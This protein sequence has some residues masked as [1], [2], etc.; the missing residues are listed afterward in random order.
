[1]SELNPPEQSEQ[2]AMAQM[3]RARKSGGGGA[4]GPNHTEKVETS[5]IRMLD[6]RGK[7]Y[8]DYASWAE[9][10]QAIKQL[11]RS[12]LTWGTLSA[13][14]QETFEMFAVKMGRLLNGDPDDIDSW[15]DIAGYSTKMIEVIRANA[16]NKP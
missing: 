15:T 7:R 13:A 11:F 12:N 1:M 6:E 10:T 16:K 9:T 4:A 3:L 2:T 14:Q 8:G 5:L